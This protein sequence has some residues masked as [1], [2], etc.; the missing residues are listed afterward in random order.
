MF[1][2]K[3]E[4]H[5]SVNIGSEVTGGDF[6]KLSTTLSQVKM[7]RPHSRKMDKEFTKENISIVNKNLYNLLQKYF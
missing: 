3:G 2:L 6:Y 5:E 4:V 7:K 1:S